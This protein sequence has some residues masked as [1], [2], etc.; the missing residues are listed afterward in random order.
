MLSSASDEMSSAPPT[1]TDD[2]PIEQLM[3]AVF[4]KLKLLTFLDLSSNT[5]T[6]SIPP[7]FGQLKGD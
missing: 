5:L 7:V 6:G 4:T 3:A 2:A 1:H